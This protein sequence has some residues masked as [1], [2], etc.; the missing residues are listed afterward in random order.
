MLPIISVLPELTQALNDQNEAVLEAPPGA[1]KTTQA[2]LSLLQESWLGNQKILM[3]E[4]RRLA[5]KAAAERMAQMLNEKAGQTVGYRVRLDTCISEQTRIEIVTEGILTRMLQTDPSL[6]GYGIVIFDEFHERSLDADLG[7]ALTLEA[8]EY[9][10]EETPLKI[11]VMSAT[12][13]G[14][15][16]AKL[17]SDAPIVTSSGRSYPVKP[18]YCGEPSQGEWLE[19][20]L[21]KTVTLALAEQTGSILCFLPGM[22]EIRKVEELLNEQLSQTEK[23]TIAIAP[24][25]GDLTLDEQRKAINPSDEGK[26]KVVLAT[27][28]AETSLTIQGVEVVIDSGLTRVAKYDPNSAMTRL[29]TRRISSASATQRA[30]RAGR[31]SPGVCYRLWSEGQQEQLSAFDSP[32]IAQA[33]LTA[34]ALQLA[35]WGTTDTNDLNW[36]DQPPAGSFQQAQTLLTQL[37]AL[38]LQK[39][40]TAHGQLM[41]E[42]P[43]HPRLS[44]MLI[45]GSAWGLAD[46]ACRIAALLMERDPFRNEGTDINSRLEWLATKPSFQKGV[47]HRIKKQEQHYHRMLS[48]LEIPSEASGHKIPDQEQAAVLL[49]LAYPDRIAQQRQNS[50]IYKLNNGRAANFYDQDRLSQY[51]WIT[52]ATLQG[53]QNQTNDQIQLAAPLNPEWIEQFIPELIQQHEVIEWD[54]SQDRICAEQQ[55]RLGTLVW[56]SAPLESPSPETIKAA[57]I[58]QIRKRGL[59]LLPWNDDIQAWRQRVIFL[60]QA[61]QKQ[62]Q[63]QWPDLSDNWLLENLEEWLAPYLNNITQLKQLKKINLSSVLQSMLPWP[64]P[65]KLDELAPERFSVPSGSK[66]RIDYSQNPPVLAVKLQEMFGCTQTPKVAN[67]VALQLHLLSPARRPLQVTQDLESFWQNA[68]KDVQKDMKGRYPKH[69]WPD[70]PLEAIATAKTKRASQKV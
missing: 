2:P 31:L 7:L 1:G 61:V 50:T 12:L 41:A 70:N 66:I 30:G 29:H 24:L 4:P 68:Y 65:Q 49:A 63:D 8:R 15:K 6:E 5:T 54:K 3:L 34:L 52:V 47:W 60:N 33:D 59:S 21:V 57:I 38:N 69:P 9:F 23:N 64:L 11:L 48:K 35:S 18:F 26:R 56:E 44:H 25:Y 36:L 53:K 16:I 67:H 28:I 19:Q 45:K 32:E 55:T 20:K 22:R 43:A 10:R 62:S 37:G 46:K 17:L 51:P 42:L 39:Q 14:E 27:N 58:N 13:D 40:T